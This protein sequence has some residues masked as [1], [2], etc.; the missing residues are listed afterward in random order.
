MESKRISIDNIIRIV[1]GHPE[2]YLF[3]IREYVS[4]DGFYSIEAIT[5]VSLGSFPCLVVFQDGAL[6]P[7]LDYTSAELDPIFEEYNK[8]AAIIKDRLKDITINY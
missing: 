2:H 1:N 5:D 4:L 7:L 8:R 3:Q 6:N